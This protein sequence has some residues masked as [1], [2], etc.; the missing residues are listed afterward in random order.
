MVN[1]PEILRIEKL[2][3]VAILQYVFRAFGSGRCSV[4]RRDAYYYGLP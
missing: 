1:F 4:T 2:P 3:G